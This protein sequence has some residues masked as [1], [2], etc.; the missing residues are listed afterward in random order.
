MGGEPHMTWR[1]FQRVIW[2]LLAVCAGGAA[3][4]LLVSGRGLLLIGKV[5]GGDIMAVLGM[6]FLL[7]LLIWGD[8]AIAAFLKGWERVLALAFALTGAF[9]GLSDLSGFKVPVCLMRRAT[10]GPFVRTAMK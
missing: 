7:T 4:L 6:V 2:T 3:L 9:I 8:G 10:A 5:S 1:W